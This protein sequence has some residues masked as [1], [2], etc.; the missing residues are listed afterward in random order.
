ML[1]WILAFL[2]LCF[3][4]LCFNKADAQIIVEPPEEF[5]AALLYPHE[6]DFFN[7]E[8]PLQVPKKTK[9]VLYWAADGPARNARLMPESIAYN[10]GSNSGVAN[11]DFNGIAVLRVATPQPYVLP[12]GT[13]VNS[14]INYRLVSACN[15]LS[16]TFKLFLPSNMALMKERQFF[17]SDQYEFLN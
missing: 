10:I 5:P 14:H 1:Y 3:L 2:L 6:P 16:P 11:V 8:I 9:Y 12:D 7:L 17:H 15:K 4:L 13:L